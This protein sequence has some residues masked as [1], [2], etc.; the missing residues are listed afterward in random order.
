MDIGTQELIILIGVN[1]MGNM[2]LVNNNFTMIFTGI[3]NW[4]NW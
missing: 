1:T 3:K 2:T 4:T